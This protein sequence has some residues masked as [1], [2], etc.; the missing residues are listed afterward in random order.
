M[1]GI[2]RPA[3]VGGPPAAVVG[4]RR[5]DRRGSPAGR[6][7]LGAALGACA[8]VAG[9]AAAVGARWESLA[10]IALPA[11][12]VGPVLPCRAAARLAGFTLVAAALVAAVHAGRSADGASAGGSAIGWRVG[13]PALLAVVSVVA[14]AGSASSRSARAAAGRSREGRR[15]DRLADLGPARERTAAAALPG[16]PAGRRSDRRTDRPAWE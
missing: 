7:L 10:V 6:A 16:A 11:L 15:A 9:C 3:P 12:F 5:T 1:R 4:H 8:A 14:S 2:R 13:H